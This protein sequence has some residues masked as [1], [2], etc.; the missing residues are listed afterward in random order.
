MPPNPARQS[1]R[2]HLLLGDIQLVPAP[3]IPTL[4]RTRQR[5][6]GGSRGQRQQRFFLSLPRRS[7]SIRRYSLPPHSAMCMR[8]CRLPSPYHGTIHH[9]HLLPSP[10]FLLF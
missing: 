7:L 3:T 8:R 10:L 6:A 9:F 4:P 5:S 1:R 2:E